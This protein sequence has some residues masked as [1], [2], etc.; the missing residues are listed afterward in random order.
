MKSSGKNTF[1]RF[2]LR[3]DWTAF[4]ANAIIFILI[5]CFFFAMGL[6]SEL[7][8]AL[9]TPRNANVVNSFPQP[10]LFE[11]FRYADVIVSSFLA[12][13]WGSI[14]MNYLNNH[15]ASNF[16]HSVPRKRTE[17]FFESVVTKFITF[18]VPLFIS[19]ILQIVICLVMAGTGGFGVALRIIGSTFFWSLLYFLLFFSIMIFSAVI[20]GTAFARLMTAGMI[21]AL[22]ALVVACVYL[23]LDINSTFASYEW[24]TNIA[25]ELVLPARALRILMPQADPLGSYLFEIILTLLLTSA[26]FGIGVFLYQKRASEKSETPILYSI[27]ADIIKYVCMFCAA[28]LLGSISRSMFDTRFS[29]L[30][31]GLFG[32]IL[33]MIVLNSIMQKSLAKMFV[34]IRGLAVFCVIFAALFIVFGVDVFGLDRYVPSDSS[35]LSMTA[36]CGNLSVKIDEKEDI[37]RLE[38]EVRAY[39]KNADPKKNVGYAYSMETVNEIDEEL[40]RQAYFLTAERDYLEISIKTRFGI[41]VEKRIYAGFHRGDGLGM[42]DAVVLSKGFADAYFGKVE[43]MPR[44]ITSYDTELF[45]DDYGPIGK[46]S[47]VRPADIFD[48]QRALLERDPL[49]YFRYPCVSQLGFKYYSKEDQSTRWRHIWIMETDSS[50]ADL[51]L[52]SVEYAQIYRITESEGKDLSAS[53]VGQKIRDKNQIRDLLMHCVTEHGASPFTHVDKDY[54]FILTFTNG[55]SLT[56]GFLEGQVPAFVK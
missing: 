27:V 17:L 25:A 48:E 23:L 10:D 37:A 30:I 41:P 40:L 42:L 16:Y 2:M 56:C 12:V 5:N 6:N 4:A 14:S 28:V 13:I 51:A 26:F 8:R 44:E 53:F 21:V 7:A 1:F 3:R 20:T 55:Q 15:V 33:C 45:Y 31:G 19:L 46:V 36:T 32:A 39:L 9:V 11:G 50:F 49:G 54:G 47:I 18:A 52:P 34:G 24:L 29:F 43:D 38:K 22:P 35:I